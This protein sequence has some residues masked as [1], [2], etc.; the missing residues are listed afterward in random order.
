MRPL[1]REGLLRGTDQRPTAWIAFK[2]RAGHNWRRGYKSEQGRLVWLPARWSGC[3]C[4]L[5]LVQ[6]LEK[7]WHHVEKV[8]TC[9]TAPGGAED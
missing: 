7:V 4:P 1:H 8:S 5:N 9:P 2:G 3:V 6:A